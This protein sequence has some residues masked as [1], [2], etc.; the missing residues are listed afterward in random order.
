MKK[1]TRIFSA[2]LAVASMAACSQKFDETDS[3]LVLGGNE[4]AAQAEASTKVTIDAGW[5]L[6]WEAGDQVDIFDGESTNVFSAK[7]AGESTTLAADDK[8]FTKE[9]GKTYYAVYPS[10][11]NEFAGSEVTFSILIP[12]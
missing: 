1:I 10:G 9:S 7:T 3:N 4:F 12:L 8:D 11:A 2:A 5:K 6:S